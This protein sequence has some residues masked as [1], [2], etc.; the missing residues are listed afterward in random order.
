VITGAAFAGRSCLANARSARDYARVPDVTIY[1][2][3]V[4]RS[5]R[6]CGIA[7]LVSARERQH[8]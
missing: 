7:A 4:T 3:D 8:G 5:G 1:L 6:D 2:V